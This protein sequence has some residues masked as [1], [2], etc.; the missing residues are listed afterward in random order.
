MRVLVA[1]LLFGLIGTVS[2][3]I[4]FLGLKNNCDPDPVVGVEDIAITANARIG[5]EP[6][7]PEAFWL[8]ITIPHRNDVVGGYLA[9]TGDAD[10][11]LVILCDG[12]STFK[13]Y[14][15]RE[16]ARLFLN[17]FGHHFLE[18]GMCVWSLDL[19]EDAPYGT[20]D[21]D[22]L[23]AA[24]DWLEAEGK[25]FLG[26]TR[27]YVVGYSTG[28]TAANV[29]NTQRNVT[30]MV[31]MAGLA[32]PNQLLEF[33]QLYRDLTALFPCNTAMDQMRYTLEACLAG[34]CDQLNVVSR[35]AD[36]KNDTLFLH[37]DDDFVYQS[38]NT[39]ALR[40]AYAA[41]VK[42]RQA[43]EADTTR[44]SA[45]TPL[46]RLEFRIFPTGTHFMYINQPIIGEIVVDYLMQFEP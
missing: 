8:E 30:A 31:S 17:D 10:A 39:R 7:V 1:I 2:G 6:G 33:A 44:E 36:F 23:V 3:C 35:V 4:D 21:A 46:P 18:A 40:D 9:K 5:I 13:Q 11:P 22:Q 14:A 34:D 43:V 20:R 19:A 45:L 15:G 29:A 12:A 41:L 28:A 26:V 25:A 16:S 24:I 37:T 27:V 32:Q 42:R 38:S